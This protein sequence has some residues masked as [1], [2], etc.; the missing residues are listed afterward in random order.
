MDSLPWR[1]HR[2][3]PAHALGAPG[4]L[5][6]EGRGCGAAE[7][8][9]RAEGAAGRDR[10]RGDRDPGSPG[11]PSGGATPPS[12]EQPP[13]DEGEQERYEQR[14]DDRVPL[15]EPGG[16]PAEGQRASPV[17]GGGPD[18]GVDGRR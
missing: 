6:G 13:D 7:G 5:A 11:G 12:A 1:R 16:L 15:R 10:V 2:P 9:G 17:V 4:L 8:G 18:G 14:D 3:P